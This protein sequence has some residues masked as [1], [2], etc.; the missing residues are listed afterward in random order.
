VAIPLVVITGF[1][2]MNIQI[3]GEKSP[4]AFWLVV[5]L[6]AVTTTLV[7]WYFRRKRWW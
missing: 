1:Y 4:H 5:G 6:M 3:P 2:G 7:L